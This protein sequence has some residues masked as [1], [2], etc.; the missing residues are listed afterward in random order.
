[1]S[2]HD[3]LSHIHT[4]SVQ[5][6]SGKLIGKRIHLVLVNDRFAQVR[7]V[8]EPF[9]TSCEMN[10]SAARTVELLSSGKLRKT[11]LIICEVNNIA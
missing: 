2:S 8:L 7:R 5:W 10:D 9:F 1:M 3:H 4:N 6:I 11:A